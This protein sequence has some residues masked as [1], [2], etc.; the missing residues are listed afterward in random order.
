MYRDRDSS[1]AEEA[2]EHHS[3][4]E[5]SR[6]CSLSPGPYLRESTARRSPTDSGRIGPRCYKTRKSTSG[7]NGS[8]D[9]SWNTTFT[10]R[11]YLSATSS[12]NV[13]CRRRILKLRKG[14]IRTYLL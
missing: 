2:S 10:T 8:T 6:A 11:S 14:D 12:P 7:R 1:Q 13:R 3:C 4:E 5:Y 9:T